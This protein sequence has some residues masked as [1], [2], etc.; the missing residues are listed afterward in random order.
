MMKLIRDVIV[1]KIE[2]HVKYFILTM[3]EHTYQNYIDLV[4][5][6]RS[7]I[8]YNAL[9]SYVDS[10]RAST[11]CEVGRSYDLFDVY[12]GNKIDFSA[13]ID[14]GLFKYTREQNID[15]FTVLL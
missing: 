5:I 15:R 7:D 10:F 12:S 9:M 2:F 6:Q 11:I 14:Q 1:I 4:N 8:S 13:P 3:Q